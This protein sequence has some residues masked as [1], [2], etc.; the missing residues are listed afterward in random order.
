MDTTVTRLCLADRN[1][2]SLFTV[3]SRRDLTLFFMMEG[4]AVA[5]LLCSAPWQLCTKDV[6]R[7]QAHGEVVLAWK[8]PLCA[9]LCTN[10]A[11]EI[12][13]FVSVLAH[14]LFLLSALASRDYSSLLYLLRSDLDHCALPPPPQNPSDKDSDDE[15]D[16]MM[17]LFRLPA[18]AEA[19][20]P[21]KAGLEDRFR[22]LAQRVLFFKSMARFEERAARSMSSHAA[23]PPLPASVAHQALCAVMGAL[24][25]CLDRLQAHVLQEFTSSLRSL[26]ESKREHVV[27]TAM[28]AA[29][30]AAL[31]AANEYGGGSDD[32]DDEAGFVLEEVLAPLAECP[33]E[34]GDQVWAQLGLARGMAEVVAAVTVFME[35]E[36]EFDPIFHTPCDV[37][38]V[39]DKPDVVRA[40]VVNRLDKRFLAIASSFGIREIN[41]VSVLKSQPRRTDKRSEVEARAE[42]STKLGSQIFTWQPGIRLQDGRRALDLDSLAPPMPVQRMH[43]L[44][45]RPGA[46]AGNE[47]RGALSTLA[48]L[49][50][51]VYEG[52]TG[53]SLRQMSSLSPVNRGQVVTSLAAHPVLPLYISANQ[54]GKI[55]LWH[56]DIPNAI[57][58]FAF[59]PS[60]SNPPVQRLRFND[61]GN[62]LAAAAGNGLLALW[63]FSHRQGGTTGHALPAYAVLD[64][65]HKHCNDV[66]FLGGG[67][68]LVTAGDSTTGHNVAVW[69]TLYE[70]ESSRVSAFKCHEGGATAL[71]YISAAKLL[72]SGGAKGLVNIFNMHTLQHLHQLDLS[73]NGRVDVLCM[74]PWADMVYAGSAEGVMTAFSSSTFEQRTEL[75]LFEK[76]TFFKNTQAHG[77]TDITVSGMHVF[78]SCREGAVKYIK[79]KCQKR[80]G[81]IF[82]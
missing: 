22:R 67:T 3:S 46:E 2:I 21:Q 7:L 72:V 30:R 61:S 44:L 49:S 76:T 14:T 26:L 25:S 77:V 80:D 63:T 73:R 60:T 23:L 10:G 31:A 11:N 75:R 24:R 71:C 40:V 53:P 68:L 37:F 35:I 47:S 12:W 32:E 20:P 82:Y 69:D 36:F 5:R 58:E 70:G 64:C 15:D 33:F 41:A 48:A 79:K 59:D 34:G 56:F 13:L 45:A 52:F 9:T 50:S 65:H 18:E 29:R 16:E 6:G 74:D 81:G 1:L 62:R 19:A 17:K 28:A 8:A 39:Q 55:Y 78:V 66:S 54:Q 38:R 51:K 27:A 4:Q 43:G 57:G 42:L